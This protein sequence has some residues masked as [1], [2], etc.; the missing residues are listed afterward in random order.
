METQET[1]LPILDSEEI[2]VLGALIEK[3]KA[4]P[5]YYPMTI[6]GLTAACNQKTSRKPI[7]NYDEQTVGLILDRLKKKRLVA[8]VTGGSSRAI[9][10]KHNLALLFTLPPDELAI[11]CLLLLR[12][13]QTPGELNTNSGRLYEFDDLEE[14]HQVLERLSTC[15]L[16]FVQLLPK[17]PGQ[18]EARYMHLLGNDEIMAL[19]AQ[20]NTA[21]ISS[22]NTPNQIEERLAHLEQELAA[23]KTAFDRLYKELNG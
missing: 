19:Y 16:P 22:S 9:K 2:R 15:S 12:G 23:L 13:P 1:A 7:V 21:S 11:V 6:N 20:E 8:T 17:Q 4:T 5:E 18:K 3:S 10:Y 14:V